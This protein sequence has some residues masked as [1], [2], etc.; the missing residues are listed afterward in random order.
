MIEWMFENDSTT[1]EDEDE[2]ILDGL[3]TMEQENGKEVTVDIMIDATEI[4]TTI[5]VANGLDNQRIAP[6]FQKDGKVETEKS[7]RIGRAEGM[8]RMQEEMRKLKNN[9]TKLK[10]RSIKENDFEELE[11]R[12]IKRRECSQMMDKGVLRS[13]AVDPE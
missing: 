7:R 8:M 9:R 1:M 2:D 13:D 3:E 5:I 11:V 12:E 4:M 10:T 6:L